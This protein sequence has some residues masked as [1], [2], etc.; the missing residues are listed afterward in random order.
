MSATAVLLAVDTYDRQQVAAALREGLQLLDG[1]GELLCGHDVLI[2]PNMLAPASAASGVCTHPSMLAALID[3]VQSRG[4][5]SVRVGDSPAVRSAAAVADAA[6]LAEI[7]RSR[8]MQIEEFSDISWTAFPQGSVS[9]RFPLA[10]QVVRADVLISAARLKTHGFT[11]F[12]GAT[13]N[14]YGCVVG[15]HKAQMHLRYN[16]TDNFSR[17]L[18][19]LAL[20]LQPR[21]NLVDGVVS[22]EGSGPR[23]GELRKTGFVVMAKDPVTADALA[24]HLIGLPPGKIG[25][26]RYAAES[27][28][29]VLSLE[30]MR[31]LGHDVEDLRVENFRVPTG[32]SV[33]TWH[34]PQ[35]LVGLVK[36][37]L[38]PRPKV[39][40]R[41]CTGC[42]ECVSICPASV[43]SPGS[44]VEISYSECIRCYCCHEVC[45]HEAIE[46]RR[47]VLF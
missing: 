40:S 39:V 2:K 5:D 7:L 23:S 11:R 22:M 38:V 35:S 27:G 13:K 10:R 36:N 19:D 26:L 16:R 18:A 28:L 15:T 24:C 6:G 44:P 9:R 14:L 43:I 30:Q 42:G 29:G 46:L 32:R 12:T 17:M 37:I 45:P 21:L 34:I 3:L 20:L 8:D 4:A 47:L 1:Q 31:I 25:H 33:A 41:A